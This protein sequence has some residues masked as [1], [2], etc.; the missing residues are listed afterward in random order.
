[1]VVDLSGVQKP[2]KLNKATTN[3]ML[4]PQMFSPDGRF[5]LSMSDDKRVVV[6]NLADQ[7]RVELPIGRADVF[8]FSAD[9]SRLATYE[10][11]K[12]GGV[13]LWDTA[14]GKLVQTVALEAGS[15]IPGGAPGNCT[16]LRFSADGKVLGLTIN[17]QRRLASVETGKVYKTLPRYEHLSTV[18]ATAVHGEAEGGLVATASEDRTVG[19]WRAAD[20][21]YLGMLEGYAA[22]VRGLAFD[23]TGRRLLTRDGR[24]A[25]VM[26]KLE[27]GESDG[28]PAVSA[29]VAWQNAEPGHGAALAWSADG[30]RI[31]TA[32]P[33]GVVR[34]WDAQTGQP[35][36]TLE[37][38]EATADLT[39]LAFS[40][41]GQTVVGGGTDG[42]VRLWQTADGKLTRSWSTDQGEVRAVAIDPRADLVITAGA[43]VRL[44][45]GQQLVLKLD[46]HTRPV[47]HVCWSADGKTVV[48]AGEDGTVVVWNLADMKAGLE[49]LGL[50]W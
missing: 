22:P 15:R 5:L 37:A 24:G 19:L 43:D 16:G 3:W 39:S 30:A 46:R 40:P 50:G 14:T 1:V 31:A 25:L 27:R 42:V 28:Q 44:W 20:G 17:G 2:L 38:P 8:C 34:L 7:K 26:W 29:T 49:T 45:K 6:W 48:T 13:K 47:N 23:P 10:A 35:L 41:D 36:H 12:N 9:G 32:G 33:K 18:S 11:G 21:Q 4:D